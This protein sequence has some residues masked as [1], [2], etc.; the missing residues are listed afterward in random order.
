MDKQGLLKEMDERLNKIRPYLN[1]DGG[2]VELVDYLDGYA[3]VRLTGNCSNCYM[4]TM[5]LK[6]GVE[7]E[8]KNHFPDL[9]GVK[10]IV[11]A[12]EKERISSSD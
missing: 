5:T 12:N 4:S 9:L 7:K 6:M 2:D 1:V 3:I 8:L 11:E 10:E